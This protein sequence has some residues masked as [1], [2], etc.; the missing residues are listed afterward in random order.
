[1]LQV[2]LALGH[3]YNVKLHTNQ[4]SA[5]HWMKEHRHRYFSDTEKENPEFGCREII[6]ENANVPFENCIFS[7]WIFQP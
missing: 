7:E 6:I 4:K 3:E 1:M 2:Q 5:D